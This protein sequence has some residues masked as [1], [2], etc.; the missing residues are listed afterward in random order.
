MNWAQSPSYRYPLRAK[1]AAEA[2]ERWRR[3]PTSR[4]LRSIN[5]STLFPHCPGLRLRSPGE[6]RPY[7]G[8][9]AKH[10][11]NIPS[12]M[13]LKTADCHGSSRRRRRPDVATGIVRRLGQ[14]RG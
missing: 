1:L 11:E 14:S 9:C 10:A 12:S 5:I 7:P 13:P 6:P 2:L 4:D 8:V 3:P